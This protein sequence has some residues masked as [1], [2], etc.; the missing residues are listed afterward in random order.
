MP[1]NLW[2]EARQQIEE[3]KKKSKAAFD[4]SRHDNIQYA[5]GE[6]VVMKRAPTSTGES[7]KLQDRYRGPLVETEV[8]PGD[9]YRVTDLAAS[10]KSRLATTAHVIQLKSWK[11]H[12]ED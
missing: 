1:E 9:V 4:K 7:T 3:A 12:E 6:V 2:T 8:F 11:L 10:K 5:V